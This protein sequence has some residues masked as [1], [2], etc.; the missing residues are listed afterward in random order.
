M[1]EA[2]NEYPTERARPADNS[3]REFIVATA[4]AALGVGAARLL[5]AQGAPQLIAG[6][7]AV[8]QPPK[9]RKGEGTM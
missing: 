3:R 7:T 4:A 9:P 6:A 2:D 8:A 1:R 5:N